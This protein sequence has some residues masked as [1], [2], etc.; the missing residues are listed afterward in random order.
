M[1]TVAT[2]ILKS[3]GILILSIVGIL[4][5]A[6]FVFAV[7]PEI[8]I[9]G[10]LIRK[11]LSYAPV[12]A[13]LSYDQVDLRLI[14][15]S[16]NRKK[17]EF[18]LKKVCIDYKEKAVDS[19][20][21][22]LSGGLSFNLFL[23][24]ITKVFPLRL[25]NA[26]ASL[27]MNRLSS[28]EQKQE[29]SS[30]NPLDFIRREILP[31][32]DFPGTI[33]ELKKIEVITGEQ[34]FL[35]SVFVAVTT[36]AKD[37]RR[38]A[39]SLRVPQFKEVISGFPSAN[40]KFTVL[41]PNSESANFESD[42]ELNFKPA[43]G[44]AIA[45][46][47]E[48]Q[49]PSW[50][51]VAY[52]FKAKVTGIA[53][54][55]TVQLLGKYTTAKTTGN[56]TVQLGGPESEIKQLNFLNC[57]YRLEL[58]E[59]TGNLSCGRQQVALAIKERPTF[60]SRPAMFKFA[61]SFE[62]K[63]TN[64]SYDQGFKTN[65]AFALDLQHLNF[66]IADVNLDGFIDATGEKLKYEAKT[67]AKVQI[68]DFKG[69]VVF[70][71]DT[72]GAIPA[73]V[74]VMSGKVSLDIEGKLNE[75]G[76]AI[77]FAFKPDLSSQHQRL[78]FT[79]N[80]KVQLESRAK[81]MHTKLILNSHLQDVRLAL[82]RLELKAPPQVLPDDRFTLAEV[83]EKEKLEDLNS[84]KSGSTFAYD[85]EVTTPQV[86]SIAIA[87]NLTK[88]PIPIGVNL[89]ADS[90]NGV[91][92]GEIEIGRVA[93]ELFRRKAFLEELDVELQPSGEKFL[94]GSIS[95][96]YLDYDISI[97]VAGTTEAPKVIMESVPPLTQDQII[98]VLLFGKA[99]DELDETQRSSVGNVSSA[100]ADAALSFSSLYFLASTPVESVGYDAQRGVVTAKVGLGKGTSLEL[101]SSDQDLSEVGVRRRLGHN[102]YLN[103]Y[104]E[105]DAQTDERSVAAFI[106]WVRRF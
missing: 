60:K 87:T 82:P 11:G 99:P 19:C 83:R 2:Y 84:L 23:P 37:N 29:E 89:T 81:G 102:W 95:I 25:I 30:S 79:L 80:G 73:P 93:L 48:T 40:L 61:P 101:G 85:V 51:D 63:L 16:I 70:L 72:P 3:F 43:A 39:L 47:L 10:S 9:P 97:R 4:I 76:G 7:V 66:M 42:G 13:K 96:Q 41:F 33:V 52:D 45:M 55:N 56:L 104:V 94:K 71:S 67:K 103:S 5:V 32:W 86:G 92:P 49:S 20:F 24:E 65:F 38:V 77:N 58:N 50:E 98:S 21:D 17:L 57:E 90:E 100:I 53:P 69:L 1:K 15:E 44:Q 36:V 46:N 106:E 34:R 68:E 31:K 28:G 64:F 62:L 26:H 74:N 6:V 27:D 91:G 54:L 18:V 8:V 12:E 59:Q 78:L 35:T 14:K 75:Q 105:E 88:N 22:E